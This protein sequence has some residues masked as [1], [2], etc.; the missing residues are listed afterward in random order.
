MAIVIN[1]KLNKEVYHVTTNCLHY[2]YLKCYI[3]ITVQR[4]VG[5]SSIT[6]N[7]C[8]QHSLVIITHGGSMRKL[9]RT[10]IEIEG[11]LENGNVKDVK[12]ISECLF[13]IL[14]PSNFAHAFSEDGEF[15]L[16]VYFEGSFYP[17]DFDTRVD[18]G[19]PDYIEDFACTLYIKE[20]G[21]LIGHILTDFL[22]EKYVEQI[23]NEMI[24]KFIDDMRAEKE[25][26]DERRAEEKYERGNT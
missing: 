18:P 21:K 25:Y 8:N 19:Y 11:T 14:S 10:E 16:D 17:G 6:S 20:E 7:S 23:K 12:A 2:N 5:Y 4:N 24:I 13:E 22:T 26:H 9:N 15:Y 1:K 3:I